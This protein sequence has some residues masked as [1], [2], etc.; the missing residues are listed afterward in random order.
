MT[1]PAASVLNPWR[2][3]APPVAPLAL[4]LYAATDWQAQGRFMAGIEIEGPN[5]G[6]EDSSGVWGAD[7]CS[8]PP[9]DQSERKEGTRPELL[10]PFDAMTVWGYD[11]C[12]LTLPSRAE[13]EARAAQ[14][15]TLE[16]PVAV[17]REFSNRLLEDSGTPEVVASLK[18]AVGYLEGEA[19]KANTP[20]WFHVGAQWASQEFGLF[21][22]SGTKF[23][24]PL[25]HTWVIGGGYVDGL[26]NTVVATS[27]PFGWRNEVAVRTAV[28]ERS[29]LYGAVAE[30]SVLV[31][32]EAVIA[33][34]Q[35]TP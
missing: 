33:A 23:V 35:V 28:D 9:I 11:E 4:G 7:W 13:V 19:A 32:Y 12:D 2:F 6:G 1:T 30:R 15:L 16:E 20:C 24:T 25:G 5:Y 8:V 18:A 17:E 10:P 21:T 31:G 27:H 34:A 22:R 29:N 26:V 3:K 14:V